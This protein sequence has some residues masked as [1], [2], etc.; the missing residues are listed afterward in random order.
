MT[1]ALTQQLGQRR[2][3]EELTRQVNAVYD[4]LVA[5]IEKYDGSVIAF[6]GDAITCWFDGQGAL[7]AVTAALA[8]QAAMTA[9][10]K[11]GLKV[12]VTT[13]PARRFVVGDPAIQRLDALAGATIARLSV[14]EHLAA[15][16]EVLIDLPTA[17]ALTD[18]VSLTGWCVAENGEHFARVKQL[19][20]MPAP[21]APEASFVLEAGTLRSW[22]L[23]VVFERYQS[24][25][26]TFLTEL[27]PAVALFLR[28]VGIDYAD[29]Q[30]GEKL[31]S[32]IVRVQAVLTR[33]EGALLQLN[34]GDKGSY[35]YAAFGAPTAHEDDVLRA[36]TAALELR[37][38]IAEFDF[39]APVQMGLSQE[40]CELVHMAVLP[41]ALM[42]CWGMMLTWRRA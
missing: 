8:L 7:R 32:L 20:A 15:T 19:T 11:L 12:A 14:G 6:A 2:G 27:R 1:E 23:P 36:V 42:G 33:Y 35:L 21:L 41:V 16:G 34:I 30:A 13:G 31:D 37:T 17:A 28:F 26:G 40:R 3:I 10:S 9:F 39:L 4:A 24:G 25:H 22:V 5:E 18:T 38:S 29:E